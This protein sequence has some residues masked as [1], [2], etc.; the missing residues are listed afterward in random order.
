MVF[1][2]QQ[3]KRN[4]RQNVILLLIDFI[5]CKKISGNF[6]LFNQIG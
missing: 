2:L 4:E 6:L 5:A 3:Q 1:G